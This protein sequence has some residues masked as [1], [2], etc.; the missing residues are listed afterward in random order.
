MKSKQLHAV[1]AVQASPTRPTT[2]WR[3]TALA[4]AA[5]LVL[6]AAPGD[7]DALALGRV[8]VLSALGEPLRAEIDVPQISPDEAASLRATLA[9]PEA[10]RAAGLNTVLC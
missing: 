4:L 10:F 8:T 5:A 7:A 1:G 3:V 2:R 9:S 6:G